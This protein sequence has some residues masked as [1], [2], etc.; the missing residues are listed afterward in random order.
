MSIEKDELLL[1]HSSGVLC[2]KVSNAAFDKSH[3][4]KHTRSEWANQFYHL[5]TFLDALF[6]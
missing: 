1:S 2:V 3:D 5:Y 4:Y 6:G